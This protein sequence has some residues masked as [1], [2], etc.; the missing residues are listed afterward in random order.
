MTVVC[1][2]PTLLCLSLLHHQACSTSPFSSTSPSYIPSREEEAYG[3]CS[4]LCLSGGG[5]YSLYICSS[6]GK[7][8]RAA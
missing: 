5:V 2:L 1:L 8:D 7:F 6:E 4:F 3:L